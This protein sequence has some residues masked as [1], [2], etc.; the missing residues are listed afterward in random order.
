MPPKKDL[1][2]KVDQLAKTMQSLMSRLPKS[3][4]PE[5]KAKPR[6]KRKRPRANL[7][8]GPANSGQMTIARS[9]LVVTVKSGADGSASGKIMLQPDQ[10]PW[11]K[12]L[13]AAFEKVKWRKIHVFWKPAG[14]AM[15]TGQI[16]V[17]M[18]WDA[19]DSASVTERNK[20]VAYEPHAYWRVRDDT[21]SRPMVIPP[22]R[23]TQCG[24]D[25]WV[26][27]DAGAATAPSAR[28]PGVLF[29]TLSS[30]IKSAVV[31]DLFICYAVVL[32]GP[33]APS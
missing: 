7:S 33:R 11:L 8:C 27:P 1:E 18:D 9:E 20:I 26:I 2:A 23:L 28:R 14:S 5:S 25:G 30:D 15:T 24:S 22:K 13:A 12:Q 3:A 19:T 21:Q 32:A 17:G 29:Y 4:A 10:Y 31:G 16:A 6:K